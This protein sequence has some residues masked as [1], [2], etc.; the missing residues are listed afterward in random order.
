[1]RRYTPLG[2]YAGLLDNTKDGNESIKASCCPNLTRFILLANTRLSMKITDI[3]R[4]ASPPILPDLYLEN[5]V[6]LDRFMDR[7]REITILLL[8]SLS[9]SLG[10]Q[11]LSRFEQS[12]SSYMPANSCLNLFNYPKLANIDQFGQ[13]KHTD[14]GSLT[15]LFADQP[16]LQILSPRSGIWGSVP[17]QHSHVVVNVGDTLRFLSGR[18][19]HSS[20]HRVV[21]TFESSQH[22]RL[23][24]GYFLRA[25]DKKIM[26]DNEGNIITARQWHDR[27]YD[28]YQAAH[29]VQKT[30]TIL[31]GGMEECVEQM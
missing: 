15:L 26:E 3:A 22:Q 27:K 21:P 6:L 16:G 25:E 28:N 30:N 31:T 1:M 5:R 8:S 7:C 24:V 11:G 4:R 18:R 14:N 13:N 19:F 2:T 9:D 10:L 20:I 17:P 29:S 23:V 12:H